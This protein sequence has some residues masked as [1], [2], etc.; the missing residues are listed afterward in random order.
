MYDKADK[1]A[2]NI[3]RSIN[4]RRIFRGINAD[5]GGIVESRV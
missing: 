4:I 5:D 3:G 1:F 2:I